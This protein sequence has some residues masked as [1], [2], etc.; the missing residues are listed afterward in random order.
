MG[1]SYNMKLGLG[2]FVLLTAFAL[3][4]VAAWFSITGMVALFSAS[5]IGVIAMMTGLEFGKLVASGVLK[6][7]WDN[8]N[9]N[10]VIKGYLLAAIATL[11]VITSIGIY[12]YL[13]AGHLEQKA[14]LAGLTVQAQQLEVRLAQRNDENTRIQQR[15]SQIDQNVAVFLRNDQGSKGLA[16]SSRLSG[17]SARL[18]TQLDANNAEINRLNEQLVPLKMQTSEVEAKLGPVKYVAALF[19]WDDT[20]AAVR[21]VIIIIMVA[22]DPLAVVLMLTALIL[23]RE[24]HEDR[25]PTLVQ[26]GNASGVMQPLGDYRPDPAAEPF[27]SAIWKLNEEHP[28]VFDDEKEEDM[29]KSTGCVFKD[30]DVAC[31][32]EDC[33]ICPEHVTVDVSPVEEKAT[34]WPIEPDHRELIENPIITQQAENIARLASEVAKLEAELGA[35][36]SYTA[37]QENEIIRSQTETINRMQK[38]LGE[39][40]DALVTLDNLSAEYEAL[41]ENADHEIVVLQSRLDDAK[42]EIENW[43]TIAHAEFQ[44]AYEWFERD[45]RAEPMEREDLLNLLEENPSII[46]EIEELVEEDVEQELTDRQKLLDLLERDPTLINDMAEIIAS[47]IV[48]PKG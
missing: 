7:N 12:G 46:D 40:R 30:I 6:M 24:W 42:E 2:I 21:L 41:K 14:P 9:F 27:K 36:K 23:I 38:E 44:R 10:W 48:G 33:R 8:R 15:M 45:R 11:M 26:D 34:E 13:S 28:G 17:E 3:S 18:Q 31:R 19:G 39:A 16:A 5:A 43:K 35:A 1:Q 37:E 4:V 25:K 29:S 22:F 32:D 20:E 47:S